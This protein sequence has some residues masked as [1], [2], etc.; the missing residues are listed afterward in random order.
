MLHVTIGQKHDLAM[1][2]RITILDSG[3][4]C[5]EG[6]RITKVSTKTFNML[7]GFRELIIQLGSA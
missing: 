6:F 2:V 7:D 5:S 4:E 3:L 1:E